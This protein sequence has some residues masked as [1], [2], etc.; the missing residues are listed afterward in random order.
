MQ[1]IMAKFVFGARFVLSV[2]PLKINFFFCLSRSE[3]VRL[4]LYQMV[5]SGQIMGKKIKYSSL[6]CYIILSIFFLEK[7]PQKENQ[8]TK[9]P[10][11]I[12]KLYKI[13]SNKKYYPLLLYGEFHI[14]SV[15]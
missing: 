14:A 13:N 3:Y 15:H 4:F 8:N 5:I 2:L 1:Q 10:A 11:S 7:Y 9:H 12:N 6:T